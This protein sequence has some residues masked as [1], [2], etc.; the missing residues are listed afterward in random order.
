MHPLSFVV[1]IVNLPRFPLPLVVRVVYLW[2]LPLTIQ[3][4]IPVFWFLGIWVSDMLRFIPVLW[5]LV[6]GIIDLRLVIPIFWFLS[7]WVINLLGWQEAPVV[8]QLA[9]LNLL[10]V[11]LDLIG[12]VWSDNQRVEVSINVI[13]CKHL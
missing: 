2:W 11:D 13:L 6:F 9:R 5:F 1:G 8:F 7:I 3:L 12:V 10:I 4:I